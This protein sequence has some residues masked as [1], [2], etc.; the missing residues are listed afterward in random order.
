AERPRDRVDV[1]DLDNSIISTAFLQTLAA[2]T[3]ALRLCPLDND[4][5]DA[6]ALES[7]PLTEARADERLRGSV[8]RALIVIPAGF[9]EQVSA[10]QP[11]TLIYR[12][13]ENITTTSYI[14]EAVN[15]AAIRVGGAIIAMQTADRI[16]ADLPILQFRDDADRAAFLEGVRTRAEAFWRT[17]P[18]SI[19][20]TMLS[21]DETPRPAT[22]AGFSQ[23]V[24]GI[25]SMYVLITVLPA[26]ASFIRERKQWTMQRMAVMPISRR[27]ILGG[28]LLARFILGL[29]QYT[30]LFG[31]GYLLGVRY[32]GNVLALALVMIT[33]VLCA[34]ALMI[35]LTGFL[36][37][38]Q[39][40][41]GITL[42]ISLTLA[43]L[44]GAWW[45]LDIVPEW[46]R[47]IG[48]ISPIAWAMDAYRSL[49]YF[50]GGVAEVMPSLIVLLAMTGVLFTIGVLRFRFD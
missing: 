34:T 31:F 23:S 43:P 1:I 14:Q 41:A 7:A 38:E 12:S 21:A 30:L 18:I 5:S 39:Q 3:P 4:D 9:G 50:G 46:M 6:C 32:G 2:D 35:M 11:A 29:F 36:K 24:P 8:T 26:A 15:G 28:K 19:N 33:F 22:A 48:H 25:A 40:A 37:T 44:G 49:M 10:G 16:A 47:I 45:P 20:Y 13:N 42:F 17:D 27:Q